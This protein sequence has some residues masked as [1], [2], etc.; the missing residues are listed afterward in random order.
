MKKLLYFLIVLVL[1]VG[2]KNAFA[3]TFWPGD[4]ANLKID[5]TQGTTGSTITATFTWTTYG[6]PDIPSQIALDQKINGIV[7]ANP[8]GTSC[9]QPGESHCYS[10]SD[11]PTGQNITYHYQ[12]GGVPTVTGYT[13]RDI[14]IGGPTQYPDRLFRLEANSSDQTV[15]SI[16]KGESATYQFDFANTGNFD[17][18]YQIIASEQSSLINTS[19]SASTGSVRAGFVGN[20]LTLTVTA[21]NDAS[22]DQSITGN[23]V[24]TSNNNTTATISIPFVTKVLAAV[25][26]TT[27]N[28]NN[29]TNQTTTSP[30][31]APTTTTTPTTSSTSSTST[32]TPSPTPSSTPP[33]STV[34]Q[35]AASTVP[36]LLQGKVVY[37]NGSPAAGS[38][39]SIWAANATAYT[40]TGSN[41]E[42]S[43][44]VF[45]NTTWRLSVAKTLGALGYKSN[46]IT[47]AVGNTDVSDV[48]ISLAPISVS[49]PLPATIQKPVSERI[50]TTL[51]NGATVDIPASSISASGNVTLNVQPTIEVHEYATSQVIGIAYDIVIKDQAGA[52]VKTFV[53]PINLTF[54]YDDSTLVSLSVSAD[55][56]V[57]SYYDESMRKWVPL[58]S[59]T[60]DKVNKRIVAKVNH[61]T[62]FAL[63]AA[64]D[65]T[66]PASPTLITATRTA[67]GV[68]IR[69]ANPASDFRHAKIYRS[70]ESGKLGTV[71]FAEVSGTSQV[72]AA[73]PAGTLYYVVR[74]VDPAGN[75]SANTNQVAVSAGASASVS[76][77]AFGHSLRLGM[78][79]NDV[80]LV[81]QILIKEGVYLEGLVTGF[82]G[83]LT[84]KAVLKFQEKYRAEILTPA[85]LSGGN[86]FAGP[87]TLKKLLEL[88][89]KYSL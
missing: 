33:A 62:R 19:V 45:R 40:V 17:D 49:I 46:G 68:L 79:G 41:G 65:V 2:V 44:Q 72:D 37:P 23:I 5:F 34:A 15:K 16:K 60:I 18:G 47:V 55:S 20:K 77:A 76:A 75:E 73:A 26:N 35:E 67:T 78:K 48:N 7:V 11:L 52:E 31:T 24:V 9:L 27:T 42:F 82:F 64:A 13:E 59:F 10:F 66:A 6:K 50:T 56:L 32:A 80:K 29:T 3:E 74:A 69:W 87:R 53:Q 81:Q 8:G 86:G 58:T 89:A 28:A 39:V 21:I 85:G 51:T 63:I 61:L 57:P 83:R 88:K 54:P 30:P 25:Q 12:I 70:T 4:V 71:V 38:L 22:S 43:F 84:E 36:A 1:C 14:T